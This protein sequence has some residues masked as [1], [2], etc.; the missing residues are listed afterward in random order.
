[1][2]KQAAIKVSNCT[3]EE[4]AELDEKMFDEFNGAMI[5][6]VISTDAVARGIKRYGKKYN[7]VT[8]TFVEYDGN[9]IIMEYDN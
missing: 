9:R 8:L 2:S 1:M 6:P 3:P 4:K 7:E 5:K